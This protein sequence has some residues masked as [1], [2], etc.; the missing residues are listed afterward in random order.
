MYWAQPGKVLQFIIDNICQFELSVSSPPVA[1]RE[2]IR[3]V[4]GFF[5]K[6]IAFCLGSNSPQCYYV[7]DCCK[8]D[9]H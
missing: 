8:E 4:I 6:G 5:S 7:L 2:D 3:E 1:T 9:G